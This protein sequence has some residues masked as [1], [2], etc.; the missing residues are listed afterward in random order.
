MHFL[1]LSALGVNMSNDD[2]NLL[3]DDINLSS[4]DAVF[5][6]KFVWT[7]SEGED[8]VD[9]VDSGMVDVD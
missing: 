3:S 9:E 7:P 2:I 5:D 1:H 8:N 4:D 6:P